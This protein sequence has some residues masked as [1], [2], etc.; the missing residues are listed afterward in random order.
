MQTKTLL[1]RK[2]F[3]VIIHNKEYDVYS[4]EGKEHSGNKDV[5]KTW[6]L[7]YSER[8]PEGMIPPADSEHFTPYHDWIKRRLWELKFK[9]Y[10]TSKFKWH[11]HSFSNHCVCEIHCNNKHIYTIH[12]GDMNYAIDKARVLMVEMSEHPYNFF[13]QEKENGRKIWWHGLP[14]TIKTGYE[15]GEIKIVPDYTTGLTKKE[16]WDELKKKET[17]IGA[18]KD[19]DDEMEDEDRVESMHDD[20]INWGDALSDQYI[21]WF[22]K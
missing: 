14:A 17:K 1:P 20:Y 13:E 21:N 19:E 9:E 8:L 11:D 15:P 3:S 18:I 16:W 5:P 2:T 6:W 7:Y 12:C 4:I 10:N 22:R